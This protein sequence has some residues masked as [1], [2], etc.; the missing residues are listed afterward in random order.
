MSAT[1]SR[2]RVLRGMKHRNARQRSVPNPASVVDCAVYVDGT[3]LP[4]TEN[5]MWWPED[6]GTDSAAATAPFRS[7]CH[8]RVRASPKAALT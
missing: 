8:R 7:P 6:G 4:D 2:R 3:R 1:P 5:Y